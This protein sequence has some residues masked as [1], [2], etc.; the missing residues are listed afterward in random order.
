MNDTDTVSREQIV[1]TYILYYNAIHVVPLNILRSKRVDFVR[2]MTI[3]VVYC[4]NSVRLQSF[5]LKPDDCT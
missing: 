5:Q 3:I 2:W 1:H 4:L